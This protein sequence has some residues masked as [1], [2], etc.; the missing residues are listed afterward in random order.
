[1]QQEYKPIVE[2]HKKRNIEFF[3]D[4]KLKE[5]TKKNI[6]FY[7][8]ELELWESGEL[9]AY[10]FDDE[11]DYE[12]NKLAIEATEKCTKAGG[13]LYVSLHIFSLIFRIGL[14]LY[15]NIKSSGDIPLKEGRNQMRNTTLEMLAVCTSK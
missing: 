9:D 3:G 11:A 14:F 7:K 6:K 4:K 2:H 15:R 12:A 1:M 10:Q 8:E 13:A 5:V